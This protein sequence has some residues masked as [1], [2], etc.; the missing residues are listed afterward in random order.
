MAIVKT[1]VKK[2]RQQA[3]VR[4]LSSISG[5]ANITL[6]DLALNDETVDNANAKVSI[7]GCYFN[8]DGI[9]TV[10]RNGGNVLILPTGPADWDFAQ[11]WGFRLDE[12][13]N[14]NARIDVSM[15]GSGTLILVLS[16]YG[17]FASPDQQTLQPRDR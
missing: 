2:T 9:S 12:G 10:S 16:K 7:S 13:A 11:A 14:A 15:S 17:G 5:T 4:F 1:I 3:V 8:T 6:A